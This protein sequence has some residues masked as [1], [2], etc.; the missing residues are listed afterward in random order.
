MKVAVLGSG[1]LAIEVA[2]EFDQVGASVKLIGKNNPG[3]HL[4]YLAKVYPELKLDFN[5]MNS[6]VGLKLSNCSLSGESSVSDIFG[7]YYEPLIKVLVTKGCFQ[8]RE[9]LRVQKQFLEAGEEI[10]GHSRLYDLFRV[11]TAL[12]PSGMVEEQLAQNP[13]LKEKIG[14][15][16]LSSLK[17]RVES[18]EDFDLV[19]DARGDFQKPMALGSCGFYALNE[20]VLNANA[21][22][23]YGFLK[24]ENLESL[25]ELKIVTVVGSTYASALNLC[26]LENWLSED[27][28]R[29]VNVVT[30]E[31]GAFKKL[32][33]DELVSPMIKDGVRKIIKTH[34]NEWRQEC[35]RVE[36]EILNWRGLEAHERMKVTPPDFPS[37]KVRIYE[38]YTVTSVDRLLDQEATFLTLE[39]PK[40]RN[41]SDSKEL[42]TLAQDIVLGS[43]GFN[44]AEGVLGPMQKEEQGFFSLRSQGNLPKGIA[45]IQAIKSI[46]LSYFSKVDDAHV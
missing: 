24:S 25:N 37:P 27:K 22:I 46:V 43:N 11:T 33:K 1:P 15:D 40:W 32:L 5:L 13:E 30:S 29:A 38:G 39:I 6:E 21:E 28:E 17:S 34:M 14:E 12:N 16:I 9:V 20:Q 45:E 3:G 18:F 19:I 7:Q 41:E 42:V 23:S 2:C 31:N 35:E 10:E 26:L 8:K 36:Q 4:R 44:E